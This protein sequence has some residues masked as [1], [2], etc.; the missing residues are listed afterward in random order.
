VSAA[1]YAR[2]AVVNNA[3]NFPAAVA[4]VKTNAVDF[5]WPVATANWGTVV[6]IG[7]FNAA[8]GG[9]PVDWFDGVLETIVATNSL[10][11]RAGQLTL[12]L[13]AVDEVP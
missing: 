8:S 1:G 6:G 9:L 2:L 3:T 4:G 11:I 12:S 13:L 7:V 5:E 10:R